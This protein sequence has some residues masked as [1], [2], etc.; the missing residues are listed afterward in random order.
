[1][2]RGRFSDGVR[3]FSVR[4]SS[5]DVPDS[6]QVYADDSRD[7]VLVI[8]GLV[9]RELKASWAPE[10]KTASEEWRE[11]LEVKAFMVFYNGDRPATGRARVCNG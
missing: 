4:A 7:L 8:S 9:S 10:W 6:F 3:T 5:A 2:E 1:M 11:W